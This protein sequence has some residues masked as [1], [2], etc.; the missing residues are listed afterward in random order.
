MAL[1]AERVPAAQALAW[2]LVNRV[3]ADSELASAAGDLAR[4]LA[5]GPASISVTRQLMF[6]GLENSLEAQLDLELAEQRRAG[7]SKDYRE[8]VAA[9]LEKRAAC[10]VAR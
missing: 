7:R 5:A 10:F 6:A 2:G 9:F 3:V 1:L 8:G 4:R